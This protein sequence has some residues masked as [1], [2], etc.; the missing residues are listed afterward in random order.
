MTVQLAKFRDEPGVCGGVARSVKGERH[1]ATVRVTI[2]LVRS[3]LVV[4]PEA[5]ADYVRQ[6]L[7]LTAGDNED[8]RLAAIT[9]G[10]RPSAIVLAIER[11][12]DDATSGVAEFLC[13]GICLVPE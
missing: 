13:L 2:A 9:L 4:E 11:A 5:V 7:G 3:A 1:A 8:H 12:A 10:D 6:K